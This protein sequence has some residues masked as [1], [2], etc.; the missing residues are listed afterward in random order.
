MSGSS[1]DRVTSPPPSPRE[2]ALAAELERYR[3]WT[4]KV[5]AACE[6]I[7]EGDLEVRILGCEDA[8]DIGRMVHGLNHFLDVTDAFVR[9]TKATLDDAS[10]GKFYRKVIL[11]GLPGSFRDASLLINA[12]TEKMKLQAGALDDA[13][14]ARLSVA[15]DFERAIDGAVAIVASS[16]TE[17]Q[18]TA[19]AMVQTSAATNDQSTVVA[20]AALEMSTSMQ[21]VASATEELS[22]TASEIR[23]Q[24]DG[25][26]LIA[27]NALN[28]AESAKVVMA[29]LTRASTE[30]GQ[31]VK[32]IS[33]IAKQTNLLALNATIEAA[34]VGEA[35]KGFAVVAGEVK[36]LARQTSGATDNI[37][38]MVGAIQSAAREG[39]EAI[40]RIDKTI[41]GYD[42]VMTAIHASVGEQR[43]ANEEISRNVQQAALGSQDV[44][45][46][47]DL[48]ARAAHE[49]TESAHAVHLT[50]TDLSRQAEGLRRAAG[51]LLT[52]IRGG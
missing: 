24:M 16:A 3:E 31:V 5:T 9:E 23:R 6:R 45:R 48:V 32:L 44:S 21:S 47:I 37:A 51:E 12:A 40:A 28:E 35:G 8:G 10:Q 38:A 25:S 29:G 11:R 52:A 46:N 13:R 2:Q 43:A 42:E 1:Y 50:A 26:R 34:R 4:A 30:I 27:R 39:V 15:G 20:A 7:S 14:E 49:T 17:L 36:S 41:H 33:E 18:A 19:A 22:A